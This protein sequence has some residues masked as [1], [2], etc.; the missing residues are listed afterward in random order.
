MSK[1]TKDSMSLKKAGG[2]NPMFGKT[3]SEKTKELMRQ[4]ALGRK[5]SE[6]TKLL[7]RSKRVILSF[8]KSVI[9]RV[10]NW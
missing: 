5:H 2:S 10:L 4:K 8:M 7:I 1:E 6:D 9:K 3:H